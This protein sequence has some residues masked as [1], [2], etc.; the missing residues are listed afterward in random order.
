MPFGSNSVTRQGPAARNIGVPIAQAPP[1]QAN[2]RKSPSGPQEGLAAARV[3]RSRAQKDK[4]GGPGV[5]PGSSKPVGLDILDKGK[6]IA[7]SMDQNTGLVTDSNKLLKKPISSAHATD[8]LNMSELKNALSAFKDKRAL[9]QQQT[10][11]I[12]QFQ[13]LLQ[14]RQTQLLQKPVDHI[15]A[16][17]FFAD[18]PELLGERCQLCKLDLKF[19]PDGSRNSA[20]GPSVHAV[21]PCG[22]CYHYSCLL[23]VFG[24][25]QPRED[26]ACIQCLEGGANSAN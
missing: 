4:G 6:E 18:S 12:R 7:P 17:D 23:D 10:D 8:T 24:P 2:K 3:T 1:A 9:T 19:A 5:E 25:L 26:P 21:L 16:E 20:S 15:K 11:Q 22:H 13:K 14:M